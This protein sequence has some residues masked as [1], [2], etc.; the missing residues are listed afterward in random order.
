MKSEDLREIAVL[1]ALD[2]IESPLSY[3][4]KGDLFNLLR[5]T[6]PGEKSECGGEIRSGA[7]SGLA[8]GNFGL[9]LHFAPVCMERVPEEFPAEKN[10]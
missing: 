8:P 7:D 10:L 1:C 5:W 9:L 2:L 6:E 3:Q 4:L